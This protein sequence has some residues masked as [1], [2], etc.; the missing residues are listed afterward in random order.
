[1]TLIQQKDWYL[2]TEEQIRLR[3]LSLVY[4]T[5]R[6]YSVSVCLSNCRNKVNIADLFGTRTLVI[7]L[8]NPSVLVFKQCS[9]HSLMNCGAK[10]IDTDVVALRSRLLL[11]PERIHQPTLFSLFFRTSSTFNSLIF[12]I[13]I[14]NPIDFVYTFQF[15]LYD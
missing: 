12:I 5:C 4:V 7:T 3:V 11:S 13:L 14:Y 10:E 8:S 2:P 15:F 9:S 6:V 1:M